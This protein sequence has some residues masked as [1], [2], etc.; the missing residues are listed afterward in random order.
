MPCCLCMSSGRCSC[1]KDGRKC[2]DCRPSR[3]LPST[4][5]RC[6]NSTA[7][8]EQGHN[9]QNRLPSYP[10]SDLNH[11]SLIIDN[12]TISI[13]S[14]NNNSNNNN[15]NNFN[16]INNENRNDIGENDH[17]SSPTSSETLSFGKSLGPC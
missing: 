12:I 8:L 11:A 3:C 10:E 6:E 7:N 2:E 14:S 17:Q 1:V 15:F 9:S 16:D 13:D 4:R 5:L